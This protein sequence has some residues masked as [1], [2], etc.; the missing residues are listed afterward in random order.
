MDSITTMNRKRYIRAL[1]NFP[2][3]R[4]IFGEAIKVGEDGNV[5]CCGIGVAYIEFWDGD[6]YDLV[7]DSS[8]AYRC[9]IDEMGLGYQDVDFITNLNDLNSATFAQIADALV[10]RWGINESD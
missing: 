2:Q 8:A 7:N 10:K 4:Q 5:G 1:R 3:E 6:F 9:I